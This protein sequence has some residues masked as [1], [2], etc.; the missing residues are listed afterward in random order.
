MIDTAK[1]RNPVGVE[2]VSVH[3][4]RVARSS[5]FAWLRRDEPQ[6]LGFDAQSLWDWVWKRG[7][8]ECQIVESARS[9]SSPTFK[10][11]GL[12][13]RRS[14]HKDEAI[15]IQERSLNRMRS[16]AK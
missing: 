4:P 15:N 12:T 7:P 3:L 9:G 13:R 1:C 16:K 8:P 5:A 6:P 10:A 2:L 11:F 14:S